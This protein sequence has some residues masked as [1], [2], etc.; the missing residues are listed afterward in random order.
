MPHHIAIQP[1]KLYPQPGYT[2]QIDK[3]GKW[4]ATQIYLCHR[5]SAIALM[6]RPGTPHPE[7]SF[8]TVSQSSATI[9][10]GDLA[11]ITCQYAGAEEKGEEEDEKANAVYTMGLSLSEEPLLS[12]LRY[13]DVPQKEREAIQLIQS[14]KDKDDQGNKLRDKVESDR[15]REALGKIDRGQTS[16]YSPRVTWRESWVRDKPASA[17]ELNDIGNIATPTGP[18]PGLAGGRNWLKNGITQTQDGKSYRLE[19]EWL[20]S[21]RGG[22]DAQIYNEGFHYYPNDPEG[23]GAPGD[24]YVKLLRLDNDGG[25]PRVKS[26]Q[27]SDIEHWAQLWTGVDVGGRC[28]VYKEHMPHD[29]LWTRLSHRSERP[30]IGWFSDATTPPWGDW[31]CLGALFR[32]SARAIDW[33]EASAIETREVF[34]EIAAPSVIARAGGTI[35]R[36]NRPHHPPLYHCGTMKFNPGHATRTPPVHHPRMFRQ[37]EGEVVLLEAMEAATHAPPPLVSIG[38][39]SRQGAHGDGEP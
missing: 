18:V 23:S 7:V 22:W 31:Y 15:G 10:E 19:N 27:Q 25:V 11:E 39:G 17:A 36:I 13:Q 26:Y 33:W 38:S 24:C 6:P 9:T 20:A 3:E 1:G 16:Y 2:L 34:T 8:I 28:R 4:T 35:N 12:H 29:G 30:G 32:V 21:D 37:A 5:S 14:G